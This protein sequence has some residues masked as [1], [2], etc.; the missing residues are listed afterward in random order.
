[1]NYTVTRKK[2]TKSTLVVEYVIL[3]T[4]INEW[5]RSGVQELK[6]KEKSSLLCLIVCSSKLL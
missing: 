1:M 2:K 3:E 5:R 6:V 4:S